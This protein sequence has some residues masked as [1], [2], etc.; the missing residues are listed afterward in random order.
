MGIILLYSL[1]I[2]QFTWNL[3]P[4]L[5]EGL[6]G[7]QIEI[8]LKEWLMSSEQRLVNGGAVNLQVV[9]TIRSDRS[10]FFIFQSA[11]FRLSLNSEPADC[12][13]PLEIAFGCCKEIHSK[14][15]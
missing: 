12:I 13:L 3:A 7:W 8:G 2:R 1:E 4:L 10:S 6:V 14:E 9:L 15:N 5:D 11:S